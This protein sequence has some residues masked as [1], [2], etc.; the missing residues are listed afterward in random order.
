M[1]NSDLGQSSGATAKCEIINFLFSDF[2]IINYISKGH[3][4]SYEH[5]QTRKKG[6]GNEGNKKTCFIL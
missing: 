1:L 4:S 3:I 6:A 5:I 2:I